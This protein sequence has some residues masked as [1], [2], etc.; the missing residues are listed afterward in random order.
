MH[1]AAEG[2]QIMPT[3]IS[4]LFLCVSQPERSV[5]SELSGPGF[6]RRGGGVRSVELFL[7]LTYCSS[8]V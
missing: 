4:D 3:G 8:S 7:P 5:V 6:N 2:E 1:A